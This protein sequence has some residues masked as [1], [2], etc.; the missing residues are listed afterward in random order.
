MAFRCIIVLHLLAK[1][2]LAEMKLGVAWPVLDSEFQLAA[3]D[4][5][6]AA[7]EEIAAEAE[8][9]MAEKEHEKAERDHDEAEDEAQELTE[10]EHVAE[11]AAEEASRQ[12]NAAE[13]AYAHESEQLKALKCQAAAAANEKSLAEEAAAA[14]SSTLE[15]AKDK[16]TLLAPAADG[17]QAAANAAARE[18]AAGAAAAKVLAEASD[19]AC[20]RANE[21]TAD[22]VVQKMKTF[23]E[24][25]KARAAM[26]DQQAKEAAVDSAKAHDAAT[27]TEEV[28]SK[29]KVLVDKALKDKGHKDFALLNAS[30]ALKTAQAK[31]NTLQAARIRAAALAA[32]T[33]EGYSMGLVR[34]AMLPQ[35]GSVPPVPT[36]QV[37]QAIDD[38][39]Q[40]LGKKFEGIDLAR[41]TEGLTAKSKS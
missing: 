28:A 17:A 41:M 24:K 20:A 38:S 22:A 13:E 29:A 31:A 14:A 12:T 16:V 25:A 40:Q 3:G 18:L 4:S 32:D 37:K 6:A 2:V 26:R 5:K 39:A 9:N 30:L 33:P 35:K 23:L 34:K 8:K 21:F 19:K 15:K 7:S 11:A 27:R 1:G 10:E 36:P